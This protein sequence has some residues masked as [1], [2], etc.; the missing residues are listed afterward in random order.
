MLALALGLLQFAVRFHHVSAR[1]SH[2]C[3]GL[4]NLAPRYFH[5]SFLLGAVQPENRSALLNVGA[6]AD[7]NFGDAPIGLGKDRDRAEQQRHVG[8]RRVVIKNGR[9][10]P[11]RQ[12]QTARNTPAKLEPD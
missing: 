4:R 6:A 8:C 9:D 3:V 1:D 5:G 7:I 11:D 12:D 10:Q 2:L